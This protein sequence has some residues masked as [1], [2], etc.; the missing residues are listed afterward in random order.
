[1]HAQL[2]V[3]ACVVWGGGEI[4]IKEGILAKQEH[5]LMDISRINRVETCFGT[6]HIKPA[7][8][9]HIFSIKIQPH[10]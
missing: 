3:C 4:N 7:P 6:L 2:S 9:K 1:M 10:N 8:K 5:N